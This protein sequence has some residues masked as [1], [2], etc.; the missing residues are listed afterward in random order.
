MIFVGYVV[1]FRKT[2]EIERSLLSLAQKGICSNASGSRLPDSMGSRGLGE[3]RFF[4]L[5]I[6]RRC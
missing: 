4:N 5:T 2:N 6:L 3:R 1:S